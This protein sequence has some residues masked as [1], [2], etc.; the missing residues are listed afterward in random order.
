MS[1]FFAPLKSRAL[2]L[3]SQVW[4]PV[5]SSEFRSAETT[6]SADGSAWW[7]SNRDTDPIAERSA[8]RRLIHMAER[9]PDRGYVSSL[10]G[11]L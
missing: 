5:V 2:D 8:T 4:N 6:P 3:S 1:L 9:P 10:F 7:I 11:P